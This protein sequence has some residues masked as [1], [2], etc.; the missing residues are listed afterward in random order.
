VW[1]LFGHI[2]LEFLD[3]KMKNLSEYSNM[4][5]ELK[6]FSSTDWKNYQTYYPL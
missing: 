3:M 6:V 1:L 2:E 4:G 5:A